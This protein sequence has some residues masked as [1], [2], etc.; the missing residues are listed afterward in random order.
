MNVVHCA[1]SNTVWAFATLG[2]CDA[3]LMESVGAE[4][5]SQVKRLAPQGLASSP[6]LDA[7]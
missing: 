3:A 7:S 4:A 5:C 1:Q 2:K 6:D